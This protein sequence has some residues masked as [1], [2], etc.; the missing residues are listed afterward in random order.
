MP[1]QIVPLG[2]EVIVT[3]G[4]A[5]AVTVS[6][7]GDVVSAVDAVVQVVIHL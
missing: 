1:E 3:E 5:V 2:L 4:V 7:A 6:V